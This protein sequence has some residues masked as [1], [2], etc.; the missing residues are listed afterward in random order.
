MTRDDVVRSPLV[1]VQPQKEV[2][3]WTVDP[4]RGKGGRVGMMGVEPI[5]EGF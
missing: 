4:P 2:R 1:D 3:G 5:L